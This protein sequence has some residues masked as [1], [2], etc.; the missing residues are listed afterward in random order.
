M[1]PEGVVR[2]AVPDRALTTSS[3]GRSTR[4]L[5]IH[6]GPLLDLATAVAGAQCNRMTGLPV[7]GPRRPVRFGGVRSD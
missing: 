2:L 4:T 5:H 1:L 7:V 3:F 6:V